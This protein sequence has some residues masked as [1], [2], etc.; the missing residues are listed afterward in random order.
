MYKKMVMQMKG[1]RVSFL[2]FLLELGG[3][4]ELWKGWHN[5]ALWTLCA[6]DV[7][8]C[9]TRSYQHHVWMEEM[10]WGCHHT[11][12]PYHSFLDQLSKREDWPVRNREYVLDE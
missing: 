6:V 4:I 10:S 3:T 11:F 1:S 9:Y 2:I 7:L 12:D 8:P 5:Y